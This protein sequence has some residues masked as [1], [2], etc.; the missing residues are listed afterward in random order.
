M[1]NTAAAGAFALAL[2]PL[3]VCLPIMIFMIVTVWKVFV[4]AGRP[5]WASIVPI[6]NVY[7]W[8]KIAGKPG[9][10]LLFCLIPVANLIVGIIVTIEIAKAFG[11]STGFAVLMI[12][13]PII[14]LPI[15]AFGDAKYTPPIP[16]TLPSGAPQA[17]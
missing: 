5:G 15:L 6:Y 3:L 11:K 1:N 13:L 17:A 10:W 14:A 4:K 2:V 7:C 9:W 16:G 12:F 8:M